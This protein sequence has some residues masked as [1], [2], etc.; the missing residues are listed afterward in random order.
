MSSHVVVMFSRFT[1]WGH[2]AQGYRGGTGE[3][4]Q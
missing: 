1:S 3:F 2:E 4:A